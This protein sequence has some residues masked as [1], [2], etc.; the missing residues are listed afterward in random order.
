MQ[1]SVASAGNDNSTQAPVN[2]HSSVCLA[3]HSARRVVRITRVEAP[4]RSP[5]AGRRDRLSAVLPAAFH[6]HAR[7]GQHHAAKGDEHAQPLHRRQALLRK[8][9]MQAKGGK[10]RRSVQNTAICEA[11]V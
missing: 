6:G 1:V 5:P 10:Q 7:Y 4:Q 2:W 3:G 11:L 8:E 9:K